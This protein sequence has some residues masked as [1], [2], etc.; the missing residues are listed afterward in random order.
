MTITH[1]YIAP[2]GEFYANLPA[3]DL[4]SAELDERQ[5]VLLAAGVERGIYEAVSNEQ[6][7]AQSAEA[8]HSEEG[9]NGGLQ[10]EG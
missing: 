1:K 4:D 10:A 3:R 8:E 5:R 6:P 2:N 7:G 9:E